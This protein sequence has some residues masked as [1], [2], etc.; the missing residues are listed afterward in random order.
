MAAVE[1]HLV[2]LARDV[3]EVAAMVR[4]LCQAAGVPLPASASTTPAPPSEDEPD[5][6]E[7]QGDAEAEGV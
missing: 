7:D 3:A 4:A 6:V 5:D 2:S 1:D